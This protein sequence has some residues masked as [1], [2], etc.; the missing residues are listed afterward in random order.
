VATC[1]RLLVGAALVIVAAETGFGQPSL[2][3]PAAPFGS[4]AQG[5]QLE[6]LARK[7]GD[8][9][10]PTCRFEGARCGYIDRAGNTVIAPQ[11]DWSDRFV[12]GRAVV[13]KDRKYGA[14]DQ[15]GK[16][17]VP[18]IYDRMSS[19]HRGLAQVLVG[20]R[21]GVISQDGQ[22]VVP[23]EHGLI[24]RISDNAF[25]VA[26]PPYADARWPKPL[27]ALGD[28]LAR[29]LP[30]AYGKRWGIVARGGAWI[31]RPKFAQV[32]AFSDDLD[33]L[34]WASDSAS[35]SAQWKPMRADGTP[36]SDKRGVPI[37]GPH[38]RRQFRR[39]T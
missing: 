28:R 7:D 5:D 25:L 11:F 4:S 16:L 37:C 1:F 18:P 2:P 32:R 31:V 19:F 26:E 38:V 21:L 15:T 9:L 12:A 14:I 22:W 17:V 20:Y 36:A 33:G 3:P 39:Q 34:F 10:I 8:T 23:A 6:T 30:C 35:L 13:G 29:S 24:V 27:N